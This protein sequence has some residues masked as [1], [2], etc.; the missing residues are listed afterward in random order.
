M[1]NMG[2]YVAEKIGLVTPPELCHKSFASQ[3][4]YQEK[5][6]ILEHLPIST[7]VSFVS[8]LYIM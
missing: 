2:N 6:G 3:R 4:V 1:K 7:V 8:W 5:A